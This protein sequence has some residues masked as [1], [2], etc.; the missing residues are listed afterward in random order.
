M[1]PT[2]SNKYRGSVTY[3]RV[4]YELMTAA[5]YRGTVTYQEIAQLMSLPM[6]GSYLARETGQ[7]LGEISED[8]VSNNR[9]MLSAVAVGVSGVPG[10]GFFDLAR[11]LG[12]FTGSTKEEEMQFWENECKAVYETWKVQLNP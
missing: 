9:P 1:S 7:I 11:D 4:F 3:H 10:S 6:R 12:V 5:R 2:V 8:E